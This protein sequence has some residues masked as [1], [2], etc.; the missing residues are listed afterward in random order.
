MRI[1]TP[2]I[3]LADLNPEWRDGRYVVFDCPCR[4]E[5][6]PRGGREMIAL[7]NPIDPTVR[8]AHN[9][10]QRRGETFETLVLSPS[11]STPIFDDDGKQIGEHW[12]GF[13]GGPSGEEPGWVVSV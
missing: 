2:P 4:Q 11:I 9:G 5:N 3:R 6:C 8:A 10:W 1:T 12:H 13:V 7:A